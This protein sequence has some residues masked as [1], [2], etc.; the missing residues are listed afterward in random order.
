[1]FF[2][3]KYLERLHQMLDNQFDERRREFIDLL[4]RTDTL[5]VVIGTNDLCV[6]DLHLSKVQADIKCFI[7]EA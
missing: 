5:V 2:S 6:S 1:M 3:A 4:S 7:D